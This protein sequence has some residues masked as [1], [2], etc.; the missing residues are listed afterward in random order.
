MG[1]AGAPA[2]WLSDVISRNGSSK[3]PISRKNYSTGWTVKGLA[4]ARAG[5]AGTLDRIF[6]RGAHHLPS[7]SSPEGFDATADAIEVYTTRPDTLFGMGFVA[8]AADHPLVARL[9]P[10]NE[11]V[12]LFAEECARLGT[13]EESI[14]SAEKR[15]VDTGLRNVNPFA[16][17]EISPVWI[18]NFVLMDYG[19][20]AVFGC[21]CGDQRDLDFARKYHLPVRSVILPPG[22]F[23]E[24]FVIEDKAYVGDGTLYNS[25]FLDGLDTETGKKRAITALEDMGVGAASAS[26]RLR[27]WGVS[28]QRY[29]GCPIPIIHCAT[30]GAVPVPDAQLRLHC[31]RMF[32]STHPAIRWITIRV[33]ST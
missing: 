29:W 15:G 9:A 5:H 12:R 18:A 6:G 23:P 14:E 21:P 11:A 2:R 20:G 19:T 16:P 33:G 4:R 28:R 26:W 7:A 3:S 25:G 30:C 17:H 22:E 10:H 27:D 24:S 13:R 31:R 8:I 1:V 32:L